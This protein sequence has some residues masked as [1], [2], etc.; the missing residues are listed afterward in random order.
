M[1]KII[2]IFMAFGAV[3]FQ[4]HAAQTF[5][6]EVQ[7]IQSMA[8]CY[9]VSFA[10]KE[11][12][13]L[14]PEHADDFKDAPYIE[15]AVEY[16]AL[17]KPYTEDDPRIVLQHV[18]S[19]GKH[20]SQK[21]WRQ[22]WTYGPTQYMDYQGVTL[23]EGAVVHNWK[24]Q[25]T[26][27]SE[28][29]TQTTFGVADDPHFGCTGEWSHQKHHGQIQSTW[30]CR[31]NAALP[32]RDYENGFYYQMLERGKKIVINNDRVWKHIQDNTKIKVDENGQKTPFV[33]EFGQNVYTKIDDSFCAAAISDW[34]KRKDN[35]SLIR[36][37]W[38]ERLASVPVGHVL[39]MM[40]TMFKEALNP[41]TGERER[42]DA[43]LYDFLD[44]E[45]SYLESEEE[46]I[47]SAQSYIGEYTFQK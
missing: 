30:S 43:H 19:F 45:T 4:V 28:K 40:D 32:R 21:H 23:E 27:A 41:Y 39:S 2:G 17:V 35:W 9:S 11:T 42:R 7:K 36:N 10:F 24:K 13:L 26:E 34:Q 25:A 12:T 38:E 47:Q 46:V 20:G 6:T 16:V 33:K 1:K 14:A 37:V 22:D 15:N 3:T 31:A 44:F 8:G 29:W 18:L 5:D